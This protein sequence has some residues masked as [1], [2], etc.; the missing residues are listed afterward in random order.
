M[1]FEL[2]QAP[3]FREEALRDMGGL[4]R[5]TAT[6]GAASRK[7]SQAVAQIEKGP[8][9]GRLELRFI[10]RSTL[11]SLRP[12]LVPWPAADYLRIHDL[13]GTA[14]SRLRSPGLFV[15]VRPRTYL[16]LGSLD[17]WQGS[18]ET[19]M[20]NAQMMCA[21]AA[22]LLVGALPAAAQT[23][24]RTTT[25][26]GTESSS[27]QVTTDRTTRH[28]DS[29]DNGTTR[30]TTSRSTTTTDAPGASGY[31]P[32]HE[33]TDA[34]PANADAPGQVKKERK[35]TSASE[36]SPGHEEHSKTTQEKTTTTHDDNDR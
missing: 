36:Y 18:G 4:R 12:R 19:T 13:R 32:G 29:D 26:T 16:A 6:C 22:L 15:R 17:G 31:A 28:T 30:S 23:S 9:E 8:P 21:A 11:N 27:G 5:P 14:A 7:R 20:R 2:D 35:S 3:K 33:A 34:R 25:T 10:T 24:S 1:T